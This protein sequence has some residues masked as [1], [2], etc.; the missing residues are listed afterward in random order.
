MDKQ[1]S[2]NMRKR[3][4]ELQGMLIDTFSLAIDDMHQ[5]GEYNASILGQARQLLKDNDVI[6]SAAEGTPL[7]DLTKVLP[8]QKGMADDDFE[9]KFAEL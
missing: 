4:E 3:M 5:S 8:F 2:D 1:L 6:T 7:N 9:K